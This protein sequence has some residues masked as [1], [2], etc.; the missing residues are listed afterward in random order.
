MI[1][2]LSEV[3]SQRLFIANIPESVESTHY[4]CCTERELAFFIPFRLGTIS[5]QWE[6]NTT[7]KNIGSQHSWVPGTLKSV[8][9]RTLNAKTQTRAGRHNSVQWLKHKLGARWI[10]SS[11]PRRDKKCLLQLPN[12]PWIPQYRGHSLGAKRPVRETDHYSTSSNNVKNVWS[13]TSIPP[14]VLI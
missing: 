1:R 9:S 5:Q 10:G 8:C 4:L 13:H 3:S 6:V 2:A 14:H 7:L 11:I 12:S